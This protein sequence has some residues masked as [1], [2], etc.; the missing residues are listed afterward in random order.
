MPH[1]SPTPSPPS[2]VRSP[3]NWRAA[4]AT[5]EP[6]S[7]GASGGAR[8][9]RPRR[10]G[11]TP[12]RRRL[13]GAAGHRDRA[14][15]ALAASACV[16]GGRPSARP[17]A[18]SRRSPRSPRR[19]SRACTPRSPRIGTGLIGAVDRRRLVDLGV[20]SDPAEVDGLILL[21]ETAGLLRRVRPRV[22]RHRAGRR[23]AARTDRCAVGR[24]RRRPPRRAAG[25]AAHRRRRLDR[26]GRVARRVPA[27]CRMARSGR[28]RLLACARPR[29]TGRRRRRRA[30]VGHAP[31]HGRGPRPRR[32]CRRCSPRRST[33]STC[34][35][36]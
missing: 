27:R 2:R 7:T 36:T 23:L 24:R 4:A 18:P 3:R 12:V 15:P 9:P 8:A 30:A 31:A 10:R 29:G 6:V 35:T 22:A 21:A 28:E 1:P 11:G 13:R 20:V 17:S 34:R 19:S 25:R 14:A 32:P 5:G 33:A 16:A 26:S